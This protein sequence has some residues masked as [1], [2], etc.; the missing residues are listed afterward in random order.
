MLDEMNERD[1]ILREVKLP[2]PHRYFKIFYYKA[3]EF[4]HAKLVLLI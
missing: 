3:H 2:A 1:D 4:Q